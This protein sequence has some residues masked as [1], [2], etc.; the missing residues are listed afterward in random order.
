MSNT[1]SSVARTIFTVLVSGLFIAAASWLVL[2]RQYAL[3]TFTNWTFEP[4][5]S[6]ATV[7]ER[8]AFTEEGE[9]IF[10]ATR[11]EVLNSDEFNS[12]CPRQ[13][14]GSPIL[15][16]YTSEDR[17]YIYNVTD[18]QLDGMKEVTAVHEMLHAAWYRMDDEKKRQLEVQLR[19]AYNKRADKALKERMA[20]YERNQPGDFVNE[21]HSILGTEKSDLGDDLERHYAEYFDRKSVLALH[22]SYN[23]TYTQLT[24]RADQ[25]VKE[26]ERL[27]ADIDTATSQ[28]NADV[29]VFSSD[30]ENFNNRANSGQFTS[31]AQFNGE[32]AALVNRSQQ[33]D[34]ARQSINN[35]ISLYNTYHAEYENITNQLEV[36]NN[37]MDSYRTIKEAPT[38]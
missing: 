36:L 18:R 34:A 32:R 28:Y 11:P 25:L 8:S 6:I 20:Y 9:F 38:I 10:V 35:T 17:I 19:A 16:C 27:A 29:S 1:K 23:S 37:G 26:M 2:N 14:T 5:A 30:V 33:L 13:E 24:T 7:S 3:D 15:G 4:S 31:T 21:L 12:E 22:A